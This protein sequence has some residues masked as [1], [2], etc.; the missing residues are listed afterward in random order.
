MK[1]AKL[2]MVTAQNNNKYYEMKQT[3][4]NYFEAC[5]GRVGSAPAHAEYPMGKWNSK[6]NEKIRKG[7]KDVTE[8]SQVIVESHKEKVK[9]KEIA[10]A[11]VRAVVEFLRNCSAQHVRR[12]YTIAAE[13]VTTDMVN[14]AQEKINVL[15]NTDDVWQFNRELVDLFQILPRA[16]K[17]VDALLAKDKRDFPEI[18]TREQNLL[19]VMAGQVV[20]N[21]RMQATDE[22]Q[23]IKDKTILEAMGLEMKPVSEAQEKEIIRHLGRN[24]SR[25]VRAWRVINKESRKKYL[26]Y[27]KAHPECKTKQYWHGSK[28]EN[29]WN[30]LLTGLKLNPNAA[31]TGKMFGKGIYFAPS[32]SKSL[33]YT[34][35]NGSYWAGGH[36]HVA[37]MAVMDVACG[38]AFDVYSWDHSY[39]NITGK[40]LSSFESDANYLYAHKDKGMLKNDELVVYAEEQTTIRYLVELKD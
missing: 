31:I 23:E 24:A 33:G 2:V 12:N 3:S 20:Q 22:Q 25:Y 38:K 14:A 39:T 8:L 32:P 5:Y 9:Y 36:S 11:S 21:N 29:F 13:A 4:D 35:I 34:S 37:Y 27:L 7:Y 10:E 18:L 40:T 30:I 6:Y 16:M 26:A 1:Y 17:Q 28:N 15:G 19:D